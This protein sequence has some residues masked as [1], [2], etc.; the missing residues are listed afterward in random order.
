MYSPIG[1]AAAKRVITND[2]FKKIFRNAGNLYLENNSSVN[3]QKMK[4]V[5]KNG[6]KNV[7]NIANVVLSKVC[8]DI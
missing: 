8:C 1:I 5:I 6:I 2:E 4:R 7:L 3:I